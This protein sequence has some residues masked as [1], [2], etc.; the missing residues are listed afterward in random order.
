MGLEP[1]VRT[2]EV[3]CDQERAFRVFI[4][5]LADWWPVAK[6]SV[7][8][9]SGQ[10]PQRLRVDAKAGGRIVETAFDGEEHVWGTITAYEPYGRILMDFH[11]ASP[12]EFSPSVEVRFIAID[13]KRTR[14]QLTQD[15]WEN[16][17]DFAEMLYS[18]YQPSWVLIFDEASGQACAA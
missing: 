9:M 18:G 13:A 14:V 15:N 2:I 6:R 8:M 12:A 1:I 4:E 3:P 7:S 16:C 10:L 17:G 5:G 11:M